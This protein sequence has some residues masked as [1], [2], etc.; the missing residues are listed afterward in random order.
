ME[1]CNHCGDEFDDENQYLD[2]LV[3]E[4]EGELSR[5]EQRRVDVHGAV[6]SDDVSLR[7]FVLQAVILLAGIGLSVLLLYFLYTNVV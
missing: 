5:I 1:T 3:T 4:H 7:A 2:H 6:A